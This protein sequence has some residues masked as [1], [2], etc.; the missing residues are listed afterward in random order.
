MELAFSRYHGQPTY[1]AAASPNPEANGSS[2]LT[3]DSEQEPCNAAGLAVAAA[4][5]IKLLAALAG[6]GV[7]SV[8]QVATGFDRVKAALSEEV[9]TSPRF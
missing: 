8:T 9:R 6:Q 1:D 4:P 2:S 7:L 5:V 3:L